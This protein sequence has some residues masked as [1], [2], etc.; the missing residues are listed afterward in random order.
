MNN[1]IKDF[2]NE[3]ASLGTNSGSD[4][5]LI[6]ELEQKAIMPHFSDK[7]AVLEIGCG[8]ANTAIMIARHYGCTIVATDF[9]E[10]MIGLAQENL[11]EPQN[12]DVKPLISLH[13]GSV[14]DTT[15]IQSLGKFDA[16]LSQRALINLP[17]A[18]EQAQ[19]IK[20]IEL[21]LATNG[22]YLMN[23]NCQQG[24]DKINHLRTILSLPEILAPWHNRY[25]NE[26]EIDSYSHDQFK[27]IANESFAS[28]YYFLSR[29][30]NAALSSQENKQ[31][32]YNAPVNLLARQ[33]PGLFEG[34]GQSRLW[35]F[36]KS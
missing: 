18:E 8:N 3:R 35:I 25:F 2:W 15:F 6:K 9:S 21:V 17:S 27:L 36:Q 19:A 22:L 12:A 34:M 30:V 5:F 26:N 23:E 33:L 31:P 16:V 13:C 20:N 1:E 29:V 24:L 32:E 7:K 11:N 28:T 10:K 4:D 14:T